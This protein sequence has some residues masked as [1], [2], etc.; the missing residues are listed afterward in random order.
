M[1]KELIPFANE[2]EAR[3]FLKDHRGR[4]VLRFSEITPAVLKELD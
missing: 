3:E 1:G 4:K 2:T